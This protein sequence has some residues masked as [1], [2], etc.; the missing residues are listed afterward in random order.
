MWA[1]E[2]Y[3]LDGL[4]GRRWYLYY[5]ASHGVDAHHRMFVCEGQGDAQAGW[6]GNLRRGG[7]GGGGAMTG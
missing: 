3:L 2:I 7:P 6:D 4:E 1:Q 5:T